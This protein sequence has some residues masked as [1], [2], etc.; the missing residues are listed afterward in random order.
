MD[1]YSPSIYN[2]YFNNNYVDDDIINND[3]DS[4][5]DIII[6]VLVDKL[7]VVC[8]ENM[9]GAKQEKKNY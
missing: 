2:V 9:E 7:K 1:W 4:S 3:N 5:D 6:D 8:K